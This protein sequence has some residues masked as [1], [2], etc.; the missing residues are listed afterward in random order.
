MNGDRDVVVGIT[1][2]S[3]TVYGIEL[4]RRLV[5]LDYRVHL[6]V[7]GSGWRVMQ[8]EMGMEGVGPSTPLCGW[9]GVDEERA[10][11]RITCYNVKDIAALP[12]SG[13][14]RARGMVIC[15]ASMKTVAAVAHGYSDSLLT[16]CADVFLKERRPLVL[17]PRETPLSAIHLANMHTL[18]VAGAH[19]LPAMPGFYHKPQSVEDMVLFVVMKVLDV[20]GIEHGIGFEWRGAEK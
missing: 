18:A 4:V 20:L 12:A 14:F 10:A 15:P 7:S 1:G 19:I 16:R 11:T 6:M 3:G 9:L 17:V 5:A 8:A 2:A 13:T